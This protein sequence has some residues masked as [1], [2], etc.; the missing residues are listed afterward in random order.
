MSGYFLFIHINQLAPV[1]SPDT[2]P[3]S[4]AYILA[5]LKTHGFS[6]HILGDFLDRPLK[7]SVLAQ[8]INTHKPRAL[9]FTVYQENIER[10]R[11]WARYTKRLDPRIHVILGGPQITYMPSEALRHMPE[12]DFLCRGDGEE[13]MLGLA[14]ALMEGKDIATV[15]GLCF[16][17]D[18]RVIET[19]PV[20]GV[21]D[22][23][24][25][26]S[27]Y[28]LDL[29]DLKYKQRVVMLTSRGCCYPC[30]F[31]YTTRASGGRVRFHSVERVIEE[32]RY[33]RSKGARDFWFADPNFSHSRR[34]LVTLLNKIIEHVPDIS[35]WCQTRYDSV[36]PEILALLKQAG[37]GTVAYGLE[38]ANPRVLEK[39]KKRMDLERLSQ[40]IRWA[41]EAGIDV[42]LFTM[43]GLPGETFDQ[44]LD[45]LDYVKRNGITVKGNSISQQV[46]LFF[47]TPMSE[48]P[49]SYGI[50]PLP[51]TRPTYLSVCRDFETNTMSADEIRRMSMIWRLNRQDFIE[52]VRAERNLF[53]RAGFI[54]QNRAALADQPEAGCLLAHIYLALEEYQ[55]AFQCLEAL[56]RNFQEHSMV[57]EILAGPFVVFK[58]KRGPAAPGYKVIYNCQGFVDG[59]IIPATCGHY[60]VSVLGDGKLLPEFEE[61]VLGLRPGHWAEFPVSF[62]EDYGLQELAG[63]RIQ[64]RVV[65]HQ[66]MEPITL[67]RAEDLIQAPRSI[68][69]LMDTMGLRQHNENLYYMVL[70]D[71]VL[72]SLTEDVVDYL[73]LI[74]FYLKLGFIDL[75][76]SLA[77][78]LPQDSML[79]GHVA[80]ILRI[81]SLPKKAMD[82]LSSVGGASD[83]IQLIRAQ[84]L[85]DLNRYQ[86]SEDILNG[87]GIP[88]NVQFLD[89][90]VQLAVQLRLPIET[91]LKRVEELLDAKIESM[92]G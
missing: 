85:F 66:A 26:A 70:R 22:L 24:T 31:C 1:E 32:M 81:N 12:V 65:L 39:I 90:R 55:A 18:G 53:N 3:I 91:Y 35:F 87:F 9:G 77:H 30:A 56:K 29:I 61:G 86:E 17:R 60:Q 15:P 69:R 92:L 42:E 33:L 50:H 40:V 80:H 76:L 71:T 4:E 45:T 23:D 13:V 46:H 52:D 7:P 34:R 47:G 10:V 82:V 58:T 54:T 59:K 20:P 38:S 6:G 67:E 27:P 43:F 8:A 73:S 11:L 79:L 89:L 49:S 5:H 78:Q 62:P 64:F 25:Y 57:K 84:S 75:G 88:G 36:S 37:A 51:R 2:I 74:N 83:G 14:Q 63:K 68:Y 19:G 16:L 21:M 44:A 41:Q 28:L 48:D 72:R